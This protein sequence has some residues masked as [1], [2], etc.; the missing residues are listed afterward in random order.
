MKK[1]RQ[2]STTGYQISYG[3]LLHQPPRH[4]C[5]ISDKFVFSFRL[6]DKNIIKFIACH[7]FN[8][9]KNKLSGY[10]LWLSFSP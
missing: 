3:N 5:F 7:K 10:K 4:A 6:R 9:N 1:S 2:A 8:K